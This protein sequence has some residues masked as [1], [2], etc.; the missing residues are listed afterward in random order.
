MNSKFRNRY[1]NEQKQEIVRLKL[2]GFSNQKISEATNIGIG[3]IAKLVKIEVPFKPKENRGYKKICNVCEKTFYDV[4]KRHNSCSMECRNK[5][6]SSIKIKY[7][8]EQ[9]KQV[10][11]FKKQG[12][13]NNEIVAKT[14]VKLSKIKEIIKNLK[15]VL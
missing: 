2:L 12:L 14:N 1:T 4:D 5:Y 15:N 6:I 11:E 9:I 8:D 7:S 10:K 3:T 13:T